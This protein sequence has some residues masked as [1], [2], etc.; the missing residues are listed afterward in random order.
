MAAKWKRSS[1]VTAPAQVMLRVSRARVLAVAVLVAACGGHSEDRGTAVEAG[2]VGSSPSGPTAGTGAAPVVVGGSAPIGVGGATGQGATAGTCS[3]DGCVVGCGN[4]KIDPGLDEACDDANTDSG[5]GCAVDCSS[6]EKDYACL[7]P[8]TACVSLVRCGDGK[9]RGAETC[10]DGNVRD[11]DG[12]SARCELEIGWSCP[13]PGSAC[14]PT[15]GDAR[16][17][18]DE[19]CDPPSVGAGCG[20][21]CR[22]EAGYACDLPP[23][24]PTMDPARCHRTVCGDGTV[25]GI[26]ACDDENTIDGD[27]CSGACTFEPECSSGACTSSCGDGIELSPEECDDGNVID[28]DG[29]ASNCTVAPGFG[30]EHAASSPLMQLNLAVT[31]RDFVSFPLGGAA[32]HADFEAVWAGD[33]VT[34][35]LVRPELDARGLPAMD[36]RCSDDQPA[37][38]ADPVSCPYGQMLGS[39]A[40][41]SQWFTNVAG[42]NSPVA[43][44]L[45]LARAAD[46][47]FAFDSGG[48][49]FYPIDGRGFTAAPAS[50]ATATADPVVNDGGEHD[51]GFTTEIRYY[52]QYLGGETLSFSGDDDLWVF[53][54]RKLALDVGGLH[55]RVARTL[56]LDASAAELGLARDGLYEIAL[57]HAE[58]HSAGSNFRLTLTGFEP[59]RSVCQATCGDGIVAGSEECDLGGGA[60]TGGYGGCTADCKRG[61]SCGDGSIQTPEETCDDGNNVTPYATDESSGCAPGCVAAGFCGDGRLDGL[62]GEECDPGPAP[63]PGSSC[64]SDCRLGA[65]CGDG[66]VQRER[67]EACDD[68]NTLSGDDCSRDCKIAV[69]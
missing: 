13:S 38:I 14:A 12:C 30:C 35:G 22:L 20:S 44:T 62:F 58:R 65:R 16:L 23:S 37:T 17:T 40:T 29:C 34:P 15:C 47:S 52:F 11:S 25:E 49:G 8:G 51:F 50:E 10:D 27:G 42:I 1:A 48:A 39:A 5:D 18:R 26:E 60:N 21:D 45:Q 36:G 3:G 43:G 54:N 7:E 59:K 6:I 66:V 9:V 2:G 56:D 68:G 28:G 63:A 53:V 31:Y 19:Q 57:F 61:P 41:F 4:G 69:D 46:G 64:S 32:R 24:P 67:G 55:T 33:D